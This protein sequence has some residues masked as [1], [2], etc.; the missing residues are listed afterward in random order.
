ME[1]DKLIAYYREL[2]AKRAQ[3]DAAY[4]E[5]RAK[6]DDAMSQIKAKLLDHMNKE[7]VESI[8]TKEG[9]AYLTV[10]T[11]ARVADKTAFLDYVIEQQAWHLLDVRAAKTAVKDMLEDTGELPPG[12]DWTEFRDVNIRKS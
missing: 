7:G 11:S 10:K 6:L 12:V 1:Y 4:K 9:T 3:L 2:M 5:Q 8:R